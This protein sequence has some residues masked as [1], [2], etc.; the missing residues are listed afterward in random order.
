MKLLYLG[1][2]CKDAL[3]RTVLNH[4]FEKKN[5]VNN[6]RVIQSQINVIIDTYVS[7]FCN[8]FVGLVKLIYVTPKLDRLGTT[9]C[10]NYHYVNNAQ[11]LDVYCMCSSNTFTT[12]S[13]HKR[14]HFSEMGVNIRSMYMYHFLMLL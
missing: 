3:D 6:I 10:E 1:N 2:G 7:S 12:Y 5:A 8:I 13:Y 11:Y 14:L 9:R 4:T